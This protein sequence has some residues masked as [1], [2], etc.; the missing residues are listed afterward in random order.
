[1]SA[2]ASRLRAWLA[3]SR[4]RAVEGD[5]RERGWDLAR[6]FA[7]VMMV[8]INFQLMLA[9]PPAAEGL[10][11]AEQI[12]RWLVHV[13]SGRSS[14]LFVVLSGV[15]FSLLTRT[16]R[17]S[18]D[19]VALR[20]A[21]RQLLLRVVFLFVLGNLLHV[22]W[23]IDILHFY[24]CY[25]LLATLLLLRAP[26]AWLLGVAALVTA[27]AAAIDLALPGRAELPYLSPLGMLLD[28]LV[29]GVHPVL[30]WLA[31]V[32][33]GAWLGRRDL[34]D[35][36]RRRAYLRRAALVVVTTE[37]ASI[38][39]AH[40]VLAVPALAPVVPS[41]GIFGTGWDPA[42]LFVVSACGT[43]TCFVCVAH[44]IVQRPPLARS[45]VVRALVRTGQ[46]ALSIYLLH[47]IVGVVL[48]RFFLGWG[49]GLSVLS[50]TLYWL[51]FVVSVIVAAFVYRSFFLR[52][53]L[54]AVMRGLTSWRL[55]SER[56]AASTIA[57]QTAA[58]APEASGSSATRLSWG[59]VLAG[60][61]LLVA[62]RVVGLST[63]LGGA[64]SGTVS[65]DAVSLDAGSHV[66][67]ELSL[68]RPRQRFW[69]EAS[70]SGE[71]TIETRSGLDLYLELD[72]VEGTTRT[73]VSEDDDSGEG[74]DARLTSPFTPGR[75]ELVVRPYAATT[76]PF[77]V[78]ITTR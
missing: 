35:A 24:A 4:A 19:R 33:W 31:F 68:A 7:I 46:L 65:L 76:G 12:L 39:V 48:P 74:V 60:A 17:Q 29:D 51:A 43:A 14:T 6:A 11:H 47:A 22:V 9:R 50:V 28:V 10:D 49:H 32:A 77:V 30:P 21:R 66:S 26:D 63:M 58:A 75:Y 62:A 52:G 67:G 15:G 38:S 18:G 3:A 57:S 25:L 42:P 44:E 5:H 34:S 70:R 13:P 16:A 64:A 59:L 45:V 54:E 61:A 69:L 2:L 36:I 55:A 40:V 20:V 71:V 72:R 1:V 23:S 37:L 73:R 53:P 8:L 78:E 41:L 27:A 56:A